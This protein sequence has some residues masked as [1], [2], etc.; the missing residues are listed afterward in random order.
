M[1]PSAPGPSDELVE[2]ERVD[3]RLVQQ[4]AR[5]LDRDPTALPPLAW[6]VDLDALSTLMRNGQVSVTF[7]YEGCEVSIGRDGGIDVSPL[8]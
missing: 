3:V 1:T 6:V 7:R 5:T 2:T 4:I 8:E